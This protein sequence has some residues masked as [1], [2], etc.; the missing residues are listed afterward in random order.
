MDV[1]KPTSFKLMNCYHS[2]LPWGVISLLS[3]SVAWQARLSYRSR[4]SD[5]G[6]GWA[7]A[8]CVSRL[9]LPPVTG[10]RPVRLPRRGGRHG[11]RDA[12]DPLW[13]RSRPPLQRAALWVRR[14]TLK[15]RRMSQL[16]P[17]SDAATS[18]YAPVQSANSDT[19][20]PQE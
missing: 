18:D 10:A 3:P 1:H 12:R 14:L 7:R 13:P 9:S 15:G 19:N 20:Y 4:L 5:S 11:G 16:S 6:P 17:K 8:C 2:I